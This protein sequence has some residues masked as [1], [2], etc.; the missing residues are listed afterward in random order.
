MSYLCTRILEFDAAH[1][2]QNHGGKCQHL[3]GHR[4][5]AEIT[6]CATNL[7]AVGVVID[8]SDIKRIVGKWIDDNLDHNTIYQEADEM[9]CALAVAHETLSRDY[10]IP[11]RAWFG[12]V[13][14]PTAENLSRLIYDVA[15]RLLSAEITVTRVRLWET[16]NCYADWCG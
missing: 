7:N 4:Y 8:F 2:I 11:H 10:E 3:H 14:A 6:C 9:M 1:R 15:K 13:L 12:T 16:P 5:K